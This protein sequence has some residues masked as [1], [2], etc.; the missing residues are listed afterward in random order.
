MRNPTT[1]FDP[2]D[3]AHYY[4]VNTR[5]YRLLWYGRKSLGIHHGYYDSDITNQEDAIIRTNETMAKVAGIKQDDKVLDAGCGVGGSSIWLAKNIGAQVIGITISNNQIKKA[6]KYAKEEGV[7]GKVEFLN[8]DFNKTEFP[9]ETFDVVWGI[10]SLCYALDK[11]KLL[12]EL[13]RI[14]KPGGRLVVSDGFILK[15][16]MTPDEQA[17]IDEWAHGYRVESFATV[18]EYKKYLDKAG[19]K[20]IKIFD[21]RT[22]V[23]KNL[24]FAMPKTRRLSVIAKVLPRL[25]PYFREVAINYYSAFAAEEGYKKGLWGIQLFYA[26]KPRK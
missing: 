20:N 11:Q 2:K 15:E 8:R 19:F 25:V 24:E 16:K 9:D 21:R 6:Y 4:D 14:L 13:Y 10:E 3:V 1:N 5:V 23:G 12:N 26:E 17:I 22:D 18:E 7:L